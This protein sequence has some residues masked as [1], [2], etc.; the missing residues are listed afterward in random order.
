MVDNYSGCIKV[1]KFINVDHYFIDLD[2]Y[3]QMHY[4][5]SLFNIQ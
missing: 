4:F 3:Q 1:I 5:R 2:N